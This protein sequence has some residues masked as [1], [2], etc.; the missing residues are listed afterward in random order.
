MAQHTFKGSVHA[1]GR[2]MVVEVTG[3]PLG[4]TSITVNGRTVYDKKPFIHTGKI[5]FQIAPGKNAEMHWEQVSATGM[6]CD[7]LADGQKT[8]LPRIADDGRVVAPVGD[9]G[10]KAFANRYAGWMLL[11][12][13]VFIFMYNLETLHDRYYFPSTLILSPLL[14]AEGI[15]MLAKFDLTEFLKRRPLVAAGSLLSMVALGIF[16]R[17]WFVASFSR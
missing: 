1:G 3:H 8:T 15:A 6:E 16:Y 2:V 10:R 9:E 7:I 17:M 13:P 12:S 4:R 14:L 5:V 11:I